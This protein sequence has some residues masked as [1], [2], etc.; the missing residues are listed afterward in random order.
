MAI[1]LVGMGKGS[2][3]SVLDETAYWISVKSS[4]GSSRLPGNEAT[5]WLDDDSPAARFRRKLAIRLLD[6]EAAKA[7][8]DS[9]QGES[10]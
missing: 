9:V 2:R 8:A 7:N 1:G 5:D 10:I 6:A 3:W 4:Q